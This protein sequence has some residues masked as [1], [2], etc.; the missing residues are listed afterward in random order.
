MLT[1]ANKLG[2]RSGSWGRQLVAILPTA[3]LRSNSVAVGRS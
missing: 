2:K 1:T 3:L